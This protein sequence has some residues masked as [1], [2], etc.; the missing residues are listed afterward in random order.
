MQKQ[1]CKHIAQ[2][3]QMS[4]GMKIRATVE[5]TNSKKRTI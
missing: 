2:D 3:K 4:E 1:T 5:C